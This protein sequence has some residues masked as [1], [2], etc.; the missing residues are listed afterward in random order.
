MRSSA[1]HR[2]HLQKYTVFC[3]VFNW[4]FD[5][6]V[7]PDTGVK[8]RSLDIIGHDA[9]VSKSSFSS[10]RCC[11]APA[12][13]HLKHFGWRRGCE[14]LHTSCAIV[15]EFLGYEPTPIVKVAVVIFVHIYPPSLYDFLVLSLSSPSWYLLV[16]FHSSE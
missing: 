7:R 12:Y 3:F 14:N 4:D 8:I 11:C 1:A 6:D 13:Q 2:L 9:L 5:I 15:S 10:S 16:H